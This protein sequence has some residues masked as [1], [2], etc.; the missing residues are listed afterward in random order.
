ML[1]EAGI[2]EVERARIIAVLEICDMGRYAPGMGEATARRRAL[3]EAA[4][5][6]EGWS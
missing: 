4:Q 3:S 1:T 2:A 6:M 5:A